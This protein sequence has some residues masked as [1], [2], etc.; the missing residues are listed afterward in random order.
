MRPFEEFDPK[1]IIFDIR[2]A[3]SLSCAS[4]LAYKSESI[5]KQNAISWGFLSGKLVEVD[6]TQIAI[7]DH[8]DYLV[9]ACRGTETNKEA[10]DDNKTFP[11]WRRVIR[12]FLRKFL[13]WRVGVD[14][15][16]IDFDDIITD[17]DFR[18]EIGVLSGSVHRG[19]K[20]AFSSA[21]YGHIRPILENNRDKPVFVTGHSLGAAVGQLIAAK[22]CSDP[23]IENPK[24][25]YLYGCP[26]V[27]DFEYSSM[28]NAELPNKIWRVTNNNDIVTRIPPWIGFSFYHPGCMV[29]LTT[30]GQV[31][32]GPDHNIIRRDR[33]K[34]RIDHI[35]VDGTDGISDHSIER[36]VKI[37]GS[38]S[39]AK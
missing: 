6:D 25:V 15:S 18:K 3:Y 26:R 30:D 33:I 21:W 9:I 23:D 28:L 4:E 10:S 12:W 2:A 27:G 20:V 5:I 13:L 16:E 38:Y 14:M 17:L 8:G 7:L 24:Q 19:F 39:N 11:L 31:L 22:M 34:G 36:Y 29:Y 32:L 37:L 35:G 1:H